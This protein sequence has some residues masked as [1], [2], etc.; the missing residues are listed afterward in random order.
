MGIGMNFILSF[1]TG[2]MFVRKVADHLIY[3]HI[4]AGVTAALEHIQR[5]LVIIFSGKYFVASPSNG[6]GSSF[7]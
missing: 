1:M 4:D 5:K 3:V 6:F 7:I 2:Q